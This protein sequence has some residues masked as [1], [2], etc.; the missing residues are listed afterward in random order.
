MSCLVGEFDVVESFLDLVQAALIVRITARSGNNVGNLLAFDVPRKSLVVVHVPGEDDVR[1]ATRSDDGSING[2]EDV[3]GA[4]MRGIE[5]K[6][7]MVNG[8]EE[9][10]VLVGIR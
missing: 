1:R 4:A 10:L 5:R 8:N 7:R 6:R 3:R 9:L 2:V